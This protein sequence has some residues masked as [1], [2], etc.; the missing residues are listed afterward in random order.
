MWR[1]SK[2]QDM[3]QTVSEKCNR[4][5]SAIEAARFLSAREFDCPSCKPVG[6]NSVLD[7]LVRDRYILAQQ[8]KSTALSGEVEGHGPVKPGSLQTRKVPIPAERSAR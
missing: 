2:I 4:A 1:R 6:W 7:S 8:L 3:L 5:A